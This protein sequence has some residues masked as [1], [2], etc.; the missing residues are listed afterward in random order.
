[1][2]HI[3]V[4]VFLRGYVTANVDAY[5]CISFPLGEEYF[6]SPGE[7][8]K[9]FFGGEAKKDTFAN[10]APDSYSGQIQP[11]EVSLEYVVDTIICVSLQVR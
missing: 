11:D 5:I 7:A 6:P 10:S 4:R 1:M 2:I 8:K 3:L 9:S